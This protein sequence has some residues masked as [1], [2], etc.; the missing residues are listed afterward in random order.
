MNGDTLLSKEGT[1]AG[2]PLAMP[3]YAL[4]SDYRA[5]LHTSGMQRM[6]Q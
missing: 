3:M 1:T 4:A 2:D 5:A 6:P